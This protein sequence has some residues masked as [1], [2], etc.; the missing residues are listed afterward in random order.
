MSYDIDYRT[1][2]KS[3]FF[4]VSTN[5]FTFQYRG[6]EL[7]V[8]Y[9]GGWWHCHS[10]LTRQTYLV[11]YQVSAVE[12]AQQLKQ[13][14]LGTTP[15]Q[16]LREEGYNSLNWITSSVRNAL[17]QERAEAA[18]VPFCGELDADDAIDTTPGRYGL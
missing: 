5:H 6:V 15:A 3:G 4:P 7:S 17:A 11:W 2:S 8:N 9:I 18:P 13:W 14:I 16:Y 10:S 1:M 12:M